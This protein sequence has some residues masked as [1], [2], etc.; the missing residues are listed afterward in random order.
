[1]TQIKQGNYGGAVA[2]YDKIMSYTNQRKSFAIID[3]VEGL[4][5]IRTLTRIA[6]Q[7]AGVPITTIQ[8][9]LENFKEKGRILHSKNEAIKLAHKMISEI[10]SQVRLHRGKGY[11]IGVNLGNL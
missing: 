10:C 11:S 2:A 8:V 3:T 7:E 6:S 1:M 4:S 5:N 9:V